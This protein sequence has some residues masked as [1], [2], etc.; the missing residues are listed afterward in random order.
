MEKLFLIFLGRSI[1][2]SNDLQ[3]DTRYAPNP[4][5][6]ASIVQSV[7]PNGTTENVRAEVE[8]RIADLAPGGG[9][10]LNAVHNV[11]PDVPPANV[12]AMYVNGKEVGTYPI[13]IPEAEGA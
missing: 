3:L 10:V 1:F 13:H 12:V 5:R 4:D 7:L 6:I 2:R 8:R 9:Y 11:Q